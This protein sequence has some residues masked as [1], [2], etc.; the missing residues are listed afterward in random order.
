M[1]L[2]FNKKF[3]SLYRLIKD[4]RHR[5]SLIEELIIKKILKKP[6]IVKDRNGFKFIL[7]PEERIYS[8]IY[9]GYLNYPEIGEQ[10]FCKNVI[11]QGMTVF[12]VGANIGQF[13][14]LFA[15][16]V[17]QEGKVY[18][19]EP[20]SSTIRRLKTHIALNGFD[21]VFTEQLAVLD[22]DNEIATINIF[23]EGNSVWNTIGNPSMP[24][25]PVGKEKVSTITI[26]TYCN[27]H[28]IKNI[29]YLKIDVEGAELEVLMG[30]KKLLKSQKI[31][32]LQFEVSKKMFE[33][34]GRNGSEI[35]MFL[36]DFGYICY[37]IL[38]DG[39]LSDSV[40]DTNSF[41]ANFVAIHKS[42]LEFILPF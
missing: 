9:T 25:K 19:F 34:M 1:K 35:F 33:G 28:G 16:L 41:F 12:D 18:S 30:C 27:E 29:D 6:V 2:R 14:I 15:H 5:K 31:K 36:Y 10:E 13:S 37:K 39:T 3:S 21:N 11:K 20:V 32:L 17:G 8:M 7:L 22:K 40:L 23:P 4:S 38:E 26:D 42:N 24:V